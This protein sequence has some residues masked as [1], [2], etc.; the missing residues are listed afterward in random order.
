M[1][2]DSDLL[3]PNDSDKENLK[4]HMKFRHGMLAH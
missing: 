2:N 3:H 1:Q 4:R